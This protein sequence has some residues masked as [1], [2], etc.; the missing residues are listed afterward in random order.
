MYKII[1]LCNAS[2][3]GLAN[4][5]RI[6]KIQTIN[7]NNFSSRKYGQSQ[8]HRNRPWAR[9]SLALFVSVFRLLVEKIRAQSKNG[10]L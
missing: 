2:A 10:G 7:M 8:F 9:W 3:L 1:G 5:I 6:R 4:T